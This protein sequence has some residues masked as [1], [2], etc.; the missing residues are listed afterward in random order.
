MFETFIICFREGAEAFLVIA[1]A[2]G[3]LARRG[4]PALL[5]ALGAGTIAAVI[6]SAVL[7]H[8]LM[9]TGGLG[10]FWEGVLA[11]T[12]LLFVLACL[13]QMGGN[14]ARLRTSI[15][16]SLD[17]SSRYGGRFA[18]LAV[19]GFAFLMVG[20]EGTEAAAMV[21]TL[22][23]GGTTPGLA[24]SALLG[25]V[26][27]ALLAMAW[28]QLGKRLDLSLFFRATSAFL[29]VFAVQLGFY[30]FHEF[31]EAGALPLVDNGY[32][33]MFSEPYGPDGAIGQLLTY[34]M[35][36]V[37]IAVLLAGLARNR[38]IAVGDPRA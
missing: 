26:A 20:R 30:A 25:I 8:V 2:A 21:A 29:A 36:L 9:D 28:A 27:A 10:S 16:G 37:P 34:A 6:A 7:G 4:R 18:A 19:S 15:A 23:D 14:G 24:L 35:V 13:S 5:A 38:L 1:I 12:A 3:Y 31:S 32:W 22:A 11:T 33:H 17:R